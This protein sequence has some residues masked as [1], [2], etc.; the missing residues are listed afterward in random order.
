VA[1][2]EGANVSV[3]RGTETP[4][5]VVGAPWIGGE[6]L[7]SHLNR[8]SIAGVRF[9]AV[10][11]RPAEQPFADRVCHGVRIALLDRAVLDAPRLGVEI[12]SALHRL[13]RQRFQLDKTLGSVGARWVLEA[14][15]DG[16]DPQRIAR[17][18]QASVE[19]FMAIR[20][21]YLVY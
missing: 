5:E 10:D 6:A 12:A 13:H 8:R 18:W 4:F 14:I 15:G 2:V 17:R 9:E 7:A 21:T 1:L 19:K 3:G 11:F 20:A 16:E